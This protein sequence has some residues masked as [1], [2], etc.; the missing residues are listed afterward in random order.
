MN[1]LQALD[2]AADRETSVLLIGRYNSD[3]DPVRLARTHRWKH[4][5]ISPIQ[6]VHS[7]KGAEADHVVVLNVSRGAFPSAIRDDPLLGL[8]MPS[9]ETYPHAEERRLLY[10]ALTRARQTVLLVTRE[11]RESPFLAELVQTQ[12]V[13]V[14]HKGGDGHQQ[15][16][17]KCR[18]GRQ[19][20]R[21]RRADGHRF[22]ACSRHECKWTGPLA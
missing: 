4:L 16:C 11:G 5:E 19:V 2:V 9:P 12:Q 1:H 22:R 10:V 6:T 8:A 3:Q 14:S 18:L 13:A 20:I 7:A 17:P 15:S 21:A